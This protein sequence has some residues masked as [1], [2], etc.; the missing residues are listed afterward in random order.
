MAWTPEPF[1]AGRLRSSELWVPILASGLIMGLAL[2]ARHVQGLFLLPVTT[3]RGWSR[4]TFALAMAAQ[5]LTWGIAQPFVGMVADRVG[6]TKVIAAGLLLYAAGLIGMMLA[7]TVPLFV[8]SAG[9]C[10]G[11]AQAGTTFGVVYAALNRL[12][13]IERRS[14]ALGLAGAIGG[15]GQFA[16]VPAT[17]VLISN[18]GWMNAL[19]SL[20]AVVPFLLP[21][22]FLLR[23]YKLDTQPSSQHIPM[24]AAIAEAFRH[25]GFWFLNTGFLACGF[26]LT[27]AATY[28]PSYL[29]DNG[30]SAS[31]GVA[32]L[33][34]IA[35]A[36]VV[37]TY[38]FGVWGGM[39]RRKY[40]LVALYL[41][42]SAAIALF[43]TVPLS[44]MSVYGFSV[45]MGFLFLS[46]VPLTN[47]LVAQIF[48]V[49][50]IGTL[51][52]ILFFS[53]QVGSFLGVWAGG[54]LF[55]V[56][57]S[58]LAGWTIAIVLG[59]VA[60]LVHWPIND[61]PIVRN[62]VKASSA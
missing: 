29:I 20:A 31:D 7:P 62:M 21:L 38:L 44:K 24:A 8:L 36:N 12:I 26:Q 41:I 57:G 51:F 1:A 37:G 25:Q 27:F 50:Y 61:R 33:A 4:E 52:G 14:W 55:E 30:M 15:L 58:Y 16:L 3:D 40:L 54:Y 28:L 9:I 19:L 5:N 46:T 53:H 2:G 35:L 56:T 18:W 22:V 45:T 6:P 49:R 60:T 39:M 42:R 23:N 48:G 32:A 10:I 17:Q 59:V 11:I 43:I 13:P 34:L 47:G